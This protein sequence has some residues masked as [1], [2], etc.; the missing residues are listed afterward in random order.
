[1]P[2]GLRRF[3]QN[4]QLHFITFSCYGRQPKL[5]QDRVCS[6]FEQSL[7]QTRRACALA[8]VGYVIMPE[9]VHLLLGEPET[10]PLATAIQALKQSVARAVALR[11]REPF[12]QARYY[13]FNVWSE[14]WRI[15]KLRYIH[16]NPV[17]VGVD[18]SKAGA[19]GSPAGNSS[20]TSAAIPA[21][22]KLGRG[23]PGLGRRCAKEARRPGHL[24]R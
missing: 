20:G 21:L 15:E 10:K 17:Q 16:S 9:H 4:R 22:A 11:G 3:H 23:T 8:V 6:Q 5:A 14:E 24:E 13:D 19:N 18:G 12:W 2:S 7:E 1:M